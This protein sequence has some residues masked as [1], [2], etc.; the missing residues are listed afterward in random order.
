[1]GDIGMNEDEIKEGMSALN[2]AIEEFLLSGGYYDADFIDIMTILANL[3]H[4][5]A[6]S[7]GEDTATVLKQLAI[8]FEKESFKIA[9]VTLEY[10]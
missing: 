2:D 6:K 7:Q 1:M 8:P 10:E 3:I 9:G 5:Y 4:Q